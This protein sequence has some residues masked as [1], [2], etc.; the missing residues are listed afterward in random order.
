MQEELEEEIEEDM[1][2]T[3]LARFTPLYILQPGE[4]E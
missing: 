3:K 4:E 2:N 1:E